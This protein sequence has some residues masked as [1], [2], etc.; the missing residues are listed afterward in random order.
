MIF[1]NNKKIIVYL[2]Y[3]FILICT[4][5]INFN[6]S[7]ANN[8]G[9]IFLSSNKATNIE[10][11]EEF[12]I[13]INL[14]N[15]K[16][17]AFTSHL[18]FD[19]T[20]V[21]YI[22]GP[23]NV[24]VIGNHIIYVWHDVTGGNNE[25]DGV[26]A[27]FK[28]KAKDNGMSNFVIDGEFYTKKEQLIEAEFKELQIQ[29]GKE[30]SKLQQEANEEQGTNIENK[31]AN[32]KVLRI[33]KE[34]LVP[35][36]QEDIYEYYLTILNDVNEIEVLAIADNPNATVE[37]TGNTNLKEGINTTLIKVT[38]EDKTTTNTYKINITK[39]NNLQTSNTNLEILAIENVLLY[40]QFDT[41]VTNY[42]AEVSN[43]INNLNVLAIPE[44]E[45]AKVEINGK[46]NIKEG[47][48]LVSINIIAQN[49]FSRKQYKIN[50]YKRNK[51]EEIKY[52]EELK[53]N[54]DKLEEIYK[55][56][57]VSSEI[58]NIIN[59]EKQKNITI[60]VIIMCILIISGLIVV[61]LKK[62]SNKNKPF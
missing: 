35:S 11:D 44:N 26:L 61:Y 22:S 29:I 25:K 17:V 49:G 12:E 13:M 41:N 46:D 19:E 31:N 30:E 37:I 10:K 32:L 16:T 53:N 50:I 28:F 42:K 14:E 39:T 57:K 9:K 18:Y 20:K 34:G 1:R 56:E 5:N 7:Y 40:P 52:N 62:K 6:K 58:E 8:I 47:N 2:I 33:D 36:F 38:S 4:L 45:N 55:E 54:K 51:E 3:I 15:N 21:E 59:E 23:E 60:Y 43:E 24:N 48:N 27:T